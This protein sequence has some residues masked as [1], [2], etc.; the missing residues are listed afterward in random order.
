MPNDGRRLV[1][2]LVRVTVPT[3]RSSRVIGGDSREPSVSNMQT[4]TAK[5]LISSHCMSKADDRLMLRVSR[6]RSVAAGPVLA[7]QNEM[8]SMT[9]TVLNEDGL[10]IPTSATQ[11]TSKQEEYT[12]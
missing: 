3:R 7:Q 6:A 2:G 5:H 11:W 1:S 4:L 8:A 9:A 10:P 12:A